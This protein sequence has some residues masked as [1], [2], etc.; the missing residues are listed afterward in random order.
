MLKKNTIQKVVLVHWIWGLGLALLLLSLRGTSSLNAQSGNGLCFNSNQSSIPPNTPSAQI[1]VTEGST[2]VQSYTIRLCHQPSSD[3]VLIAEIDPVVASTRLSDTPHTLTFSVTNWSTPQS[4][5]VTAND[6]GFNDAQEIAKIRYGSNSSDPNFQWEPKVGHWVEVTIIDKDATPT[7]RTIYLPIVAKIP[8]P[9]PTPTP[10]PTPLPTWQQVSANDLD[11]DVVAV[12]N[13]SLFLG[14]GSNNPAKGV[15]KASECKAGAPFTKI[16]GD[17]RVLDLFFSD[18]FALLGSRGSQVFHSKPDG[19]NWIK[20]VSS[21]M[22]PFVYA[23]VKASS[24]NKSFAGADDGVYRSNDDGANLTTGMSWSLIS[25]SPKVIN[26]FRYDGADTIWIATFG[27]GVSKYT[28]SSDKF[29]P[30]TNGLSGNALQVWDIVLRGNGEVYIATTEGVY[31]GTGNVSD[32]WQKFTE[33]GNAFDTQIF[34]LE[35]VQNTLYAGTANGKIGL[36]D[37]TASAGWVQLPTQPVATII[38]DLYY[39]SSILCKGGSNNQNG[40]LAAT[41]K[42]VWL[43]R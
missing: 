10:S 24:A 21:G 30:L 28:I 39:D 38:R 29:E 8:P 36:R 14:E 34:T 3:V 20:T 11:V 31:K 16:T 37:L 15:Y 18:S 17:M 9:S 5:I 19:A 6:N 22:N 13:G 33:T 1:T 7:A 26:A 2:D 43:Y 4:V 35:F 41:N 32:P 25:G 12:H 40:L 23:V 27:N 42:G